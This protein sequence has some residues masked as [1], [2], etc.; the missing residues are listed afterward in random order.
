MKIALINVYKDDRKIK[1][2]QIHKISM[3]LVQIMNKL[4]VFLIPS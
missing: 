3:I 2:N 1:A 4:I